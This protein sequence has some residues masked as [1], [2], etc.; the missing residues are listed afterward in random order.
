MEERRDPV[1][2]DPCLG[3]FRAN[4]GGELPRVNP[5]LSF[6]GHFGPVIGLRLDSGTIEGPRLSVPS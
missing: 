4:S 6:R 5:G 3:P 1:R 2:V